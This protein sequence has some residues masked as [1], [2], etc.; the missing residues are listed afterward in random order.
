MTPVEHWS[1]G[2]LL[3]AYSG[4]GHLADPSGNVPCTFEIVQLTTGRIVARCEAETGLSFR[5]CGTVVALHGVTGAV[6]SVS[7]GHG[8]VTEEEARWNSG[9]GAMTLRLS[10]RTVTVRSGEGRGVFLRYGLTNLDYRL[11]MQLTIDGYVIDIQ[12]IEDARNIVSAIRAKKGIAVTAEA[13]VVASLDQAEAVDQV[14]VRLC[15]L[16]SLAQGHGLAWVHREILDGEGR[17]IEALHGD[18]VTKP[19][20][21]QELV[22]R[23]ATQNFLV[24]TYP[25]FREANERVDLIRAIRAFTDAKV[26]TPYLEARALQIV[27]VMEHLRSRYARITQREFILTKSQFN[28]GRKKL[29]TRMH[30]VFESASAEQIDELLGSVPG[31]NRRTFRNILM[32][33][34]EELGIPLSKEEQDRFIDTRDALVH[35]L[36]FLPHLDPWKEY[37]F[38]ATTVGK[39]LL[40]TLGWQ[41]EY[42]DWSKDPNTPERLDLTTARGAPSSPDPPA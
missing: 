38:L 19:W 1:Y 22:P 39:V 5:R 31:L 3:R 37:S 2:K 25:R 12:P 42:R 41:G 23:E 9:P 30:E 27:I 21:G 28:R 34:C 35:T 13:T 32:P 18:A 20:G 10:C 8:V 15:L 36:T 11:Q 33:L 4:H 14:I 29:K 17:V 6:Q 40:A 7:V 24:A 16:L 26:E